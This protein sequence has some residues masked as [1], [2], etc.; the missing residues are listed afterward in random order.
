MSQQS[1]LQAMYPNRYNY[2]T[3]VT[4]RGVSHQINT[5]QY[6]NN[7]ESWNTHQFDR[8]S[9]SVNMYN[10]AYQQRYDNMNILFSDNYNTQRKEAYDHFYKRNRTMD[11]SQLGAQSNAR[12]GFV[13]FQDPNYRNYLQS[14]N[15]KRTTATP[16]DENEQEVAPS[17]APS[18]ASNSY[19]TPSFQ[20]Y[21]PRQAHTR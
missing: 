6:Y 1:Q 20:G 8:N 21:V 11:A 18:T 15:I 12:F 14:R 2:P 17:P 16:S 5:N 9:Q 10:N 13:D 19:H 4:N 3:E 7:K